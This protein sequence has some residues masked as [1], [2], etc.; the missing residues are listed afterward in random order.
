MKYVIT[1]EN[2][3]EAIACERELLKNEINVKLI[4]TPRYLSSSCGISARIDSADR[5][6]SLE[7]LDRI[8]LPYV[9]CFEMKK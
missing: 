6:S 8:K 3:S 7:A 2:V 9:G 1:F 5:E 4:P